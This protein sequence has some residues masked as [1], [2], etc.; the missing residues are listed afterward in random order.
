[1]VTPQ[2][3]RLAGWQ[4]TLAIFV[5]AAQSHHKVHLKQSETWVLGSRGLLLF[6]LKWLKVIIWHKI[7]KR[8]IGPL[9]LLRYILWKSIMYETYSKD[10]TAMLKWASCNIPT[11]IMYR[12]LLG[13]LIYGLSEKQTNP[14]EYLIGASVE[15]ASIWRVKPW[16]YCWQTKEAI[17]IGN[18]N[19][20]PYQHKKQ[21]S[22]LSL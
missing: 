16:P 7:R 5:I 13:C 20:S 12:K 10:C 11:S 15:N 1:M 4:A 14:N 8:L 17:I 2:K 18:K 21:M 6:A 22:Q 19:T 3:V 9:S